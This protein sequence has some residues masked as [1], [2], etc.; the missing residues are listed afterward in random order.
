[1]G[2]I[3]KECD[4]DQMF[5]LPPSMKEWLPEGH[6]AY[7]IL[8]VVEQMDLT[9]I[10]RHYEKNE[11]GTWKAA[12]GQPPFD[13]RMMTTLIVYGYAVGV[14]SSGKIE[15]GCEEDLAFRIIAANQ[16]PN[17]DTICEFRRVHLK[18]LENLFVQVLMVCAEAGLVKLGHVAIDGTKVRANASKHK[19]MSYE[20]MTEK[21]AELRKEVAALLAKAQAVDAEEDARYG[22]NKRGEDLPTE[23]RRKETRLNRILKAK[24]VVEERAKTKAIAKGDLTAEGQ[25][26]EKPGKK[27]AVA[28]G[29]PQG[30]DQYNFT[31]PESRIMKNSDKAFV[32]AY[33]CQAAVDAEHQ[34]IVAQEVTQQTN[35][36]EQ[37]LPMNAL[38]KANLGESPKQESLD[39][40]Y[41]SEE[42]VTGLENSGVDVYCSPD[43]LKHGE[44]PPAARGRI[45]DNI[46]TEDRMRRKLRTD[47]GRD[48]YSLRK[49]TVEPTF[50]QIKNKGLRQ[51]LLRGM[52]KV[53]GEWSLWCTGHNLTKL[54]RNRGEVCPDWF[55]NPCEGLGM[56]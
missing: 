4:R 22:K 39:A 34:I 1:M 11:D 37:A 15:R 43:R 52:K 24:A 19:A 20:R 16:R 35:D 50:G 48:L 51:F 40:G 9:E 27:P 44:H 2:Q 21:E 31:D 41:F 56:A 29:T 47:R 33:N 5:L 30:K 45:P 12:S 32:Q 3:Y 13:P 54:W 10:E 26:V 17:H 7:F 8:D 49:E 18:A 53:K 6:L 46:T 23:L 55:R 14:V 28:P 25:V 42:N 38:V 36:K